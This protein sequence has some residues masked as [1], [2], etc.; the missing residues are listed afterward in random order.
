[1][2]RALSLLSL[3]LVPG[4]SGCKD[5][6]PSLNQLTDEAKKK[7]DAQKKEREAAIEADKKKLDAIAPKLAEK[8][9]E[10]ERLFAAILPKIPAAASLKTKKPC[11]DA[12]ILADV[13]AEDK[14]RVLVFNQENLITLAG[15]ADDKFHT[16]AV[17]QAQYLRRSHGKESLLLEKKP[18]ETSDVAGER[19]AA[20][21]YVLSFRYLGVGVFTAFKPSRIEGVGSTPARVDGYTVIFDKESKEPL[22]HIET[23]GENLKSRAEALAVGPALYEDAWSMWLHTTSKNLDSVSKALSIEGAPGKK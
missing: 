22:C 16:P 19:L 1:M 5:D 11:P 17:D 20:A 15:K 10:I 3:V 21:E 18:A 23:W 14:R 12:K 9:K 6:K 13:P 2:K 7:D 4:L 8:Q